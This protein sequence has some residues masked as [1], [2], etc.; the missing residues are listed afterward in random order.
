MGIG[1]RIGLV[2]RGTVKGDRELD[3]SASC[4]GHCWPW[5]KGGSG[6]RMGSRAGVVGPGADG[7]ALGVLERCHHFWR[8]WSNYKRCGKLG[9]DTDSRYR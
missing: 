6:G 5:G 4:S 8:R 3:G 9:R 1:R 2:L 7:D